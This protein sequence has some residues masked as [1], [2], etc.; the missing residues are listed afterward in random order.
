MA[1]ED[2]RLDA[3]EERVDANDER[4]I[5]IDDKLYPED[6]GLAA[7]GERNSVTVGEF[8]AFT[9]S[10]LSLARPDTCT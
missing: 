4:M 2:E 1:A 5:A 10:Y 7:I 8:F 9:S 6:G 3:E